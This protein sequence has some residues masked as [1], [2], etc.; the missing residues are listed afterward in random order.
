MLINRLIYKVEDEVV[1]D[2]DTAGNS[3]EA[4]PVAAYFNGSRIRFNINDI[5]LKNRNEA[6][7]ELSCIFTKKNANPAPKTED[8]E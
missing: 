6:K 7:V 4:P 3:N 2:T 1:Y 8:E 5:K